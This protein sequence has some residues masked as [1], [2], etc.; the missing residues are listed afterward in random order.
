MLDNNIAFRSV[1]P[2]PVSLSI[3]IRSHEGRRGRRQGYLDIYASGNRTVS[4]LVKSYGGESVVSSQ[5]IAPNKGR[6][7]AGYFAEFQSVSQELYLADGAV[8]IGG[9]GLERYDLR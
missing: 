2:L 7:G 6:W 4:Q 9:C 3:G 1:G 5:H 8:V